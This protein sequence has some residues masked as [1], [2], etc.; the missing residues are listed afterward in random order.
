MP[1][2]KIVI[3]DNSLYSFSNQLSNGILITSFYNDRND[4][5]LKDVLSYLL[6]FICKCN[7]VRIVNE[8]VFQLQTFYHSIKMN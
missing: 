3:I 7:D 6:N 2:N 5:Q 8:E 4:T 1:L